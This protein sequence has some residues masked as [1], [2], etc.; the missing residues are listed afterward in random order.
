MVVI[1]CEGFV[2]F[3]DCGFILACARERETRQ[4]RGRRRITRVAR[5]PGLE[6]PPLLFHVARVIAVVQRF[7]VQALGVAGAVTQLVGLAQALAR[8]R[9]FS[10]AGVAEPDMRV[11]QRE[12]RIDR[13][14]ALEQRHGTP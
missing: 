2:G 12:I 11:R 8:A 6:D 10:E 14:R 5:G 1:D 7:D 13:D 9:G 4:Q 3:G